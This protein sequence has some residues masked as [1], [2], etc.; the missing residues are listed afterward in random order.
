MGSG[1]DWTSARKTRQNAFVSSS[2]HLARLLSS[3]GA[4]VKSCWV[5]CSSS[6][7][8]SKLLFRPG[9]PFLGGAPRGSALASP[10]SEPLA[11]SLRRRDRPRRDWLRSRLGVSSKLLVPLP[12]FVSAV[13]VAC[14]EGPA[15]DALFVLEEP[16][17]VADTGA[18]RAGDEGEGGGGRPSSTRA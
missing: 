14:L 18:G 3:L 15:T 11:S 17:E 16:K 2:V 7:S 4:G 13:F 9:R 6:G 12:L 10:S 1:I 8:I 5:T